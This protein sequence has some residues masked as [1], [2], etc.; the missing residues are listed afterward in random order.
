MRILGQVL[1]KVVRHYDVYRNFYVETYIQR[2]GVERM[3][4]QREIKVQVT[5]SEG[6][7]ERFTRACIKAAE[8]HLENMQREQEEECRTLSAP[9]KAG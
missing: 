4:Q 6:Y 9:E 5:F 7:Q 8:R 2:K 3:R 1:E